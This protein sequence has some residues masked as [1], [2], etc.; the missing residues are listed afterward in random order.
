MIYR[1]G[2]FKGNPERKTLSFPGST[3]GIFISSK[4]QL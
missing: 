1:V 3:K 4:I 2:G